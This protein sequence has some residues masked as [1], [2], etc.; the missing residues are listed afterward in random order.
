M[1]LLVQCR[2]LTAHLLLVSSC[3]CQNP[4]AKQFAPENKTSGLEKPTAAA[5]TPPSDEYIIGMDDVLNIS[6]WKEPEISRTLP[7]RPDGKIT[8]PLV[9]EIQA[10]GLTPNKLQASIV[11]GLRAYVSN[12]DVTVIVQEVKSLKFNIVG[13][14]AKPGSYPLSKPMTVLDAIAVGG[15]LRDFAKGNRIYVLRVAGNGTRTRLPFE[16]KQVIKGNKL[17]ENV[18]LQSGDTIV[19][20]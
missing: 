1:K 2:W 11:D 6:V 4:E 13:E 15:G 8:L 3:L 10:S 12:P 9:G 14:I 16:Y 19:I 17:A 18:E 5:T 20:P 7:V